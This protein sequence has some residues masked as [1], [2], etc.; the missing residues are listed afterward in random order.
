MLMHAVTALMH[1]VTASTAQQLA[2]KFAYVC[3]LC[4]HFS[5][6]PAVGYMIKSFAE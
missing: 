6:G 3:V 2:T 1:A 5:G 4:Q